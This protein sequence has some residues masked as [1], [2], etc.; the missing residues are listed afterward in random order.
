MLQQRVESTTTGIKEQ[1]NYILRTK[2]E[3]I[4]SNFSL[5]LRSA[6][7][8]S[9]G[10]HEAVELKTTYFQGETQEFVA[11][12]IERNNLSKLKSVFEGMF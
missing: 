5:I 3:Q 8:F 2:L 12:G 6:C 9:H 7:Y 4:K 10:S 1:F 11:E